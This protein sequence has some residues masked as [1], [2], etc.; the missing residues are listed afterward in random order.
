MFRE[1]PAPTR[2]DIADVAARVEKRTRRWLRRRGLLDE[3]AAEDR[4][5][6]AP[7][8]SP[9]EACM[10]ISLFGSTYVYLAG[11]GAAVPLAREEARFRAAGKGP[12]VAEASGFNVHAG[13][14]VRAGDR[15]GL[16]R[17]CRYGARPPFS[18]ERLRDPCRRPRGVP[19]P[20][21][22]A[23]RRDASRDD[24]GAVY[25]APG[26]LDSSAPV[27]ITA[28][29]GRVRAALAAARFGGPARASESWGDGAAREEEEAEG[30]E[31]G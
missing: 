18:L 26:E 24:A 10:Q 8:L 17:L 12:W 28:L 7:E 16:E 4:S 3:R 30:E 14:M 25:I 27:S 9:L 21:A 11:D 15:E 6:E 1:G 5:N 23:Q 19:P 22:E 13:V 20:Q 2:G 29:V 31:A